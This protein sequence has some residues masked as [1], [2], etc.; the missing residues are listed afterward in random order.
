MTNTD[1]TVRLV[2]E[3]VAALDA[4]AAATG[5]TRTD[6]VNQALQVYAA[7]CMTTDGESLAV[8]CRGDLLYAVTV[9]RVQD[10]S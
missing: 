9:H 2:P 3:A 8:K 7:I 1:L 5:D 10:H 4:A 6:I